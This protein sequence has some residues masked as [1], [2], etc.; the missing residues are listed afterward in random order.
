MDG[1]L[2]RCEGSVASASRWK[3]VDPRGWRRITGEVR[4]TL[5]PSLEADPLGQLPRSCPQVPGPPPSAAIL[6]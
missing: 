1:C 2:G 4:Q 6:A 3:L 5:G